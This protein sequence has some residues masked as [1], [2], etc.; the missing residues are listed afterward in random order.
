[1]RRG[2][3]TGEPGEWEKDEGETSD[4]CGMAGKKDSILEHFP[5]DK[6]RFIVHCQLS[7]S[8]TFEKGS[9]E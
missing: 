1:M 4:G 3:Y 9:T 6:N 7:I 5:H 8:T 2:R